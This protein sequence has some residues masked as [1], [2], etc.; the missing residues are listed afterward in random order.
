VAYVAVIFELAI[1]VVVF[2]VA[3]HA[4]FFRVDKYLGLVAIDAFDVGV[5]PEQ[6]KPRQVMIKKWCVFPG[7]FVVAVGTLVT[8][9]TFVRIILEMAGN[10]GGTGRCFENWL[11]VAIDAGILE[12]RTIQ[13]KLGVPVVI[14]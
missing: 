11:N 9:R 2:Q 6:R 4:I 1:V 10:T 8:F 3:A 13:L 12:M 5:F 14:E 7:G